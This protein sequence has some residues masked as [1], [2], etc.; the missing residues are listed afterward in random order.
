MNG[1][2]FPSML[3]AGGNPTYYV[4]DMLGTSRVL[5]TNTGAVC[6]DADFYP[7]GG[8]RAY[9]NTC[10]QNYKFE[11]KERDTETGNDDFGARYYSNRFGRWLSA[12]WSAV[13]VPI[14]YANLSNP[15]TLNLYAMVAD[16]PESFADLDGHR[17]NSAG[18]ISMGEMQGEMLEWCNDSGVHVPCAVMEQLDEDPMAEALEEVQKRVSQDTD[19]EQAAQ[20]PDQTNAQP[21]QNT[22]QTETQTQPK[23]LSAEDVSKAIQTAKDEPKGTP[24]AKTAVDFLNA[25]GTNWNLSG[26]TLRQALKDSKVD[27]HGIDKKVDSISRTGDV[28]TVKLNRTINYLF[29]KTGQTKERTPLPITFN[30]GS[31][32]GRPA[33]VNI[34]GVEALHGLKYVPKTQYGPD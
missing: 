21:A 5:T 3:P 14:P 4:E 17:I 24:H 2:I 13:P 10:S 7:Y 31:V 15:Q 32:G 19:Q 28:V 18:I 1:G 26:D 11:G 8:E 30:V 23:Q 16:D 33:L 25:L 12:D 34:Q 9:T 6:Y 22:T 27:A 20:T 29:Y